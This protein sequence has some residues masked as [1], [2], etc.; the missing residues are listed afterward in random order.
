MKTADGKIT[1]RGIGGFDN[2]L[3]SPYP[4][5]DYSEGMESKRISYKSILLDRRI[6]NDRGDIVE[7][8]FCVLKLLSNGKCFLDGR[9]LTQ[10]EDVS[11]VNEIF[12]NLKLSE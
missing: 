8:W 10:K 9:E 2:P 1:L 3:D 6:R 5:K 11:T 4:K 7:C 12:S